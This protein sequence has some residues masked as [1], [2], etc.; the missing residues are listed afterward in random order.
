[1]IFLKIFD[2]TLLI[3]TINLTE[4][5]TILNLALIQWYDF[6]LRNQYIY[7]CLRLE[8]IKSFNFIDI[9]T[10]QDIVHIIPRCYAW[11]KET[12]GTHT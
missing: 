12:F 10:I 9:E 3:A 6:K 8:I 1:M 4:Q 5:N 2:K 11:F 7:E